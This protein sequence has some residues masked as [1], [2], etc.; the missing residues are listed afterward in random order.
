MAKKRFETVKIVDRLDSNR[1]LFE[2]EVSAETRGQKIG[3][4][5]KLALKAGANLTD[6]N[7]AGADLAGADLDGACLARAYLFNANLACADLACANL[8][9]ANMAFAN[10]AFA[11]LAFACLADANLADANLVGANLAYANLARANLACADLDGAHL[12]GAN[13][14]GVYLTNVIGVIRIDCGHPWPL[15]IRNGDPV[16]AYCGCR[17]KSL[18]DLRAHWEHHPADQRREL[19]LPALDAAIAKAKGWA[20]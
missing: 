10:M 6:A 5:V 18:P 15:I 12:G 11:N 4:A 1:V 2:C 8:D 16:M 20:L 3:E 14:D 13:L 19:M 17:W 9:G 7:L